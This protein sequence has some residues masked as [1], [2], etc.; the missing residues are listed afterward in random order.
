[1]KCKN[2]GYE[3]EKDFAY[4][5]NCGAA[6]EYEPVAE[7]ISL[8]PAADKVLAPLQTGLF[9][10]VCIL[11]TV[12]TATSIICGSIPLINIL[13][14]IFLWCVYSSAQKGYADVN[15][16]RNISGTVYASYV[17]TNV[18]AG[19][20]AVLGV[21]CAAL[22]SQL[23]I[24]DFIEL[25][26]DFSLE[27]SDYGISLYDLS[28]GIT[29]LVGVIIAIMFI[30]IAALIFVINILGVKKIHRFVKSVYMGVAYQNPNFEKAVAAKNWIMVFAVFSAISALGDFS[31]FGIMSFAASGCQSAALIIVYILIDR[32]FVDKVNYGNQYYNG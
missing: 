28:R 16:L 12:S 11:M 31:I 8:N 29:S 2:C 24:Y 27:L 17:I 6:A 7:P 23:N 5:V 25:F 4:C 21:L 19:I 26:E 15:Q 1:M 13:I 3:S 18:L 22:I 32:Y 20:F 30:F 9:L 10:A 14:T